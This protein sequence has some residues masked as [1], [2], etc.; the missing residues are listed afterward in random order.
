MRKLAPFV[1]LILAAACGGDGP[2]IDA[3]L[4]KHG[5]RVISCSEAGEERFIC[6]LESGRQVQ[7]VV[8]EGKVVVVEPV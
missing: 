2:D 3:E 6:Q 4:E 8:H 7:A 5:F 1:I